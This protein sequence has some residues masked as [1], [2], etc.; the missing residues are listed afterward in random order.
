MRTSTIRCFSAAALLVGLLAPFTSAAPVAPTILTPGG[1]RV[2]TN[3]QQVPEGGRI[4][5]VG[6][7]IHLIAANGTVVHVASNVKPAATK[8]KAAASPEETGWVTYAYWLNTGSSPISSFTTT[9]TVPAVPA[10]WHGQTLFLFNSIEPSTG[11]AIM[12]P[13]LQYGPSAAG[14]GEYWAVATWYLYGSNVFFTNP[15]QVSVGQTLNGIVSLVGQSGSTYNYDSQFTNIGGT[16]LTVDGGEQLT[17]A[18]ETLEAYSVTAASD[19]PTGSTVFSGINLALTSGTP[20]VS[21]SHVD[22]TAD[23]LSTSIGVNGA[24]NAQITIHY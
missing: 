13:V 24:T 1:Y 10:T 16:A 11:D 5:H 4:A 17:W 23:G 14:G 15:I 8:V 18:T 20:S 9:W 19:Y 12:Q 3:V 7:D 2:S 21:W 22:D 6:N